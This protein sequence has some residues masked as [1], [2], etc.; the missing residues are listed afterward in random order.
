MIDQHFDRLPLAGIKVVDLTR[1]LAGPF[2][3]ALLGDLGAEVI[4]VEGLPG[5]D[6]TRI[7]PPYGDDDASLYY[8][9]TNRNKRS[10]ALDMRRPESKAILGRLVADADVLVENFRPGVLAKLDLDLETLKSTR[11][12]LVISSISGFGEIGPMR[13]DAGLDQ[14]AQGMSGLMSVTG[15][16][17]QTPMRVGVPIS[18]MVAGMFSALGIVASLVGRSRNQRAVRINT[19]LLE[20]ALVLMSFQA[21]RYLSV[22]EVP[23]AQG[24]DHPII[25]PY[26]TFQA[27]DG[28]MNVAVGT[29]AQWRVLCDILGA[30]DLSMRPE[31]LTPALRTANRDALA[32]EL[33]DLFGK[34]SIH[35]WLKE[36]RAAGVPSGPIYTMDQVFGDAQVQALEMV[37]TVAQGERES[38]L[39]RGPIWTDGRFLPIRHHPPVLGEHTVEVLAAAGYSEG[40]IARLL[41][42][43]CALQ[44]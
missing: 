4:K 40:E 27:A 41:T 29:D 26:G 6:V 12:D 34:R 36:L 13:R 1:A 11:P 16:G 30:P 33:N 14:I 22:G 44:A 28:S 19:S 39:L 3:T 2:C 38:R 21:Q 42:E 9:S 18:D 8:L 24:N 7:W 43:G 15:A 37:Q 31:Y 20:S 5:G 10:I 32:A 35:A 25:S 23:E 17:D